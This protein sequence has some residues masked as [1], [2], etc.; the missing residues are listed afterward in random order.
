[1]NNKDDL[2]SASVMNLLKTYRNK[3]E[4]RETLRKEGTKAFREQQQG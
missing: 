1:M 4:Q 3:I 2:T